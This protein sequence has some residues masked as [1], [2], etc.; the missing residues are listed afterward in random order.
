MQPAQA[1]VGALELLGMGIALMLDQRQLAD[2]RI[3]LAQLDAAC[4]GQPHQAFSRPVQQL[5]IGRE[6]HRL[7]LHRR[8]DDHAR[9]VGRLDRLGPRRHRQALLDQRRELLLAHAL[10]PA[11]QR[12]AIEWQPV[13]EEL[14]A[15]EELVIG[16][17]DPA[18]TQRLV[19]QVVH[20]LEDAPSPAISRVG[21][22]G[23][24][25]PSE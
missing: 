7:R 9:Q 13:L 2:P 20:V 10:P 24:P 17:L 6:H 8:I 5:G 19:G 12:R 1:S 23:Q 22:G 14:L 25:G 4:A 11:C 3:G 18:L 15:A 16:V 21:S